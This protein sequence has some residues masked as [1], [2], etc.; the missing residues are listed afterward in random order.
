[1][2]PDSGELSESGSSHQSDE[3]DNGRQWGQRPQSPTVAQFAA[4]FAQ[5]VGSLMS[6]MSSQRSLNHL[7]TDAELEADAERE[8]E[9]SR[10]EAERILSKEA[11]SRR[12]E[13]RVLAMLEGGRSSPKSLP[14]PPPIGQTTSS[15]PP[16]PSNSQKEREG[17]WT[18]AKS[19]LTPTKD[20]TPAQQVIQDTKARDK[21]L[22]KERKE[23][24]KEKK[25]MEKEMKKHAKKQEKQKSKEWPSSAETKFSDPAFLS[26][27]PPLPPATPVRQMSSSPSPTPFRPITP[28]TPPSLAASPLRLNEPGTS[29]PSRQPRPLYAQ[30]DSQGTL[31]VPGT[32][33]TIAQRFEKLE[34]WTVGHVRALE[35]RMDDVERW[36]VE[37]EKGKEKHPAH[38][39]I[40]NQSTGDVASSEALLELR[41]ELAEVQ[42]RIGELGREMA[43]LVTAPNN[44]S[45]G[46]SRNNALLYRSPSTSSSIAI[47]SISSHVAATPRRVTSPNFKD[48][49]SPPIVQSVPSSTPRTRLPY[50]TGDYATPP[51]SV[52]ISQGPFS[53]PRSPPNSNSDNNN[54]RSSIPGLP[55]QGL[56]YVSNGISPSGL[57]RSVS[58]HSGAGSPSSLPAPSL[59]AARQSSVSPTPRKR[60]T[61]ALGG[62][63]MSAERDRDRQGIP[64]PP[65][66]DS[67]NALFSSSPI[68]L[69]PSVDDAGDDSE[70]YSANEET[71][72]RSAARTAGLTTPKA[73]NSYSSSP[74]TSPRSSPPG[75][76][77]RPQSMYNASNIIAPTPTTPLRTRI[78]SRST[79]G[80]GLAEP[81]P[82]PVTASS[83]KF[84]DPLLIRRQTQEALAS[85]APLP[86][87][88]MPGKPKVPVGQLV[89]FFDQGK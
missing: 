62:P 87:K 83:D 12:L 32:L 29:S 4:N 30:F 48:G 26:L 44:L 60:Y 58:P 23:I 17:W 5:R 1:M 27:G 50:P 71:I 14:P 36:L 51:D 10:R 13:E 81:V 45:S 76:R 57:P 40:E 2:N 47:R 89:A 56:E 78:R 66:R 11:E 35:E 3:F 77:G 6:N 67:A 88:V 9:K 55:S 80:L 61:V 22:E 63:I 72:G 64:R 82:V 86:P 84:V 54:R 25:G 20:L 33:L 7:P 8:R 37:K 19:K 46:P 38:Q 53:P 39:A 79:V 34:R 18:I 73:K 42:G 49:A 70:F 59:P 16:S 15:T 28:A 31:D 65:S 52:F 85:S 74:P 21:H 24:E 75:R 68:S 41:E 43:K 69:T